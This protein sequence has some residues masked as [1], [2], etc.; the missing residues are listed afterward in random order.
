ML[1][2]PI[3]DYP[4]KK[5]DRATG[6]LIPTYGASTLR[7][8]RCT[9]RSSGRSIAARTRRSSTSGIRRSAR[10]SPASTATTSAP[11]RTATS[12]RICLDQHDD[13]LQI[14]GGTA[15]PRAATT[16]TA[17]EPGA[18]ARPPCAGQRRLLLEPAD[19]PDVQH[20]HLRCVAEQPHVRREHRR[21]VGGLQPQRDA[22]SQRIFL[23]R[24]QLRAVSAARRES[25]SLATNGRSF[26]LPS[27]FR[28]AANTS[29][30]SVRTQAVNSLTSDGPS[31]RRTS[32]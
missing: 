14:D 2:V 30:C 22:G 20:E 29:I 8:Q 1:Y 15:H 32:A 3:M 9:T 5:E 21:R 13:H 25:T 11:A 19:A 31:T 10:A 7:G 24:Q 4:T 28:S 27:T 26:G 17:A 12:R 23:R 18:A 16:S 6:F